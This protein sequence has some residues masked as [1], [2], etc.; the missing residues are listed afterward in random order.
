[1]AEQATQEKETVEETSDLSN[2]SK[3]IIEQI[4]GMTVLELSKLVKL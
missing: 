2:E 4:E 1:M 3:K